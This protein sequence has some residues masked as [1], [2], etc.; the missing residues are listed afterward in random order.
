MLINLQLWKT[1]L[2]QVTSDKFVSIYQ[3]CVSQCG[4]ESFTVKACVFYCEGQQWRAGSF[5]ATEPLETTDCWRS[6]NS[7]FVSGSQWRKKFLWRCE[8]LS[9][10]QD[11]MLENH[12]RAL[13]R[14]QTSSGLQNSFRAPL[15]V[16][17]TPSSFI[18]NL[19]SISWSQWDP[20]RPE[21]SRD[22]EDTQTTLTDQSITSSSSSCSQTL[23]EPW[24]W[25]HLSHMS[26]H[27]DLGCSFIPP[28][29]ASEWPPI[30]AIG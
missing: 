11:K 16:W 29:P 17:G 9:E 3:G 21:S 8:C 10:F 1:F 28:H 19:Y 20:E 26:Q 15:Q 27:F 2:T 18:S 6:N 5:Q 4:L 30:P 23:S 25:K 22:Q 13:V 24:W 7:C 12:R 14:S